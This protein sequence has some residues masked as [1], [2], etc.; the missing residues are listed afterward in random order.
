MLLLAPGISF[1]DELTG[2][3]IKVS[4][5]CFVSDKETGNRVKGTTILTVKVTARATVE[6][7]LWQ[8]LY[9][10]AGTILK[11]TVV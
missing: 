5:D 8:S 10:L 3:I 4:R 2:I 1:G 9:F 6:E 11:I 7:T